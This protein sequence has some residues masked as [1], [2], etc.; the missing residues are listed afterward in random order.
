MRDPKAQAVHLERLGRLGW[1]ER[2]ALPVQ[3]APQAFLDKPV[4]RGNQGWRDPLG[5]R[6][7]QGTQDPGGS[8]GSRVPR[9]PITTM[10]TTMTTTTRITTGRAQ[11]EPEVQKGT[12]QHLIVKTLSG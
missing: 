4:N 5:C 9:Y 6:G 10:T 12:N 8:Q 3:G 11:S 1:L 7:C 2:W